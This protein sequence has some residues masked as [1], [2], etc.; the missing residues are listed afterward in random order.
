[1]II[2]NFQRVSKELRPTRLVRTWILYKGF[3]SGHEIIPKKSAVS[4]P[5]MPLHSS[6]LTV[7]SFRAIQ[8]CNIGLHKTL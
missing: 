3:S 1:M 6:I 8:R 5:N 2:G 7:N 4:I